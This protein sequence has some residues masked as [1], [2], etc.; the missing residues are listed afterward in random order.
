MKY[1]WKKITNFFY[2]INFFYILL[3]LLIANFPSLF[4][5][6]KPDELNIINQKPN[7]G[8]NY[9]RIIN[10]HEQ[11]VHIDSLIL[12]FSYETFLI[13]IDKKIAPLY[14]IT[15]QFILKDIVF[16]KI[17]KEM[18]IKLFSRDKVNY[19]RIFFNK[20]D[21]G[22][23]LKGNENYYWRT[24]S[25]HIFFRNNSKEMICVKSFLGTDRMGR[26]IW[27][28]M[29]YGS[30]VIFLVIFLSLLISIPLGIIFGLIVG[31]YDNSISKIIEFLSNIA[32]SLPIYL[33]AMLVVIIFKQEILYIVIAFSL[34]QWVEIEKMI[35][36]KT[37]VLKKKDFITSIKLFGKKDFQ[38]I[39]SDIFIICIPETL[40]VITYLAKRIILI[41]AGLSYLGYSV[42]IPFPS[43]GDIIKSNSSSIYSNYWIT[44]PPILAIIFT[45]LSLNTIENLLKKKY[46]QNVKIR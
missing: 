18:E 28:R 20:D 40:I 36:D 13:K 24:I 3:F 23:K 46:S 15:Q 7:Q 16:S 25:K 41:E 35:S 21:V 27:A 26:D 45:T 37:K 11:N 39:F 2:L 34:V 6:L 43:W 44:I 8:L 29:V 10:N 5:K 33:L 17:N 1:F 22:Y 31:Y 12:D 30:K 32:N 9:L 4:S 42:N 14:E 38:V 19:L